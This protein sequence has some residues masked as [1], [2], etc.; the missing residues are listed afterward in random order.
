MKGRFARLRLGAITYV[1]TP[2]SR[3]P[4]WKENHTCAA[5]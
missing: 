4:S 3:R 5:S 2:A 1:K